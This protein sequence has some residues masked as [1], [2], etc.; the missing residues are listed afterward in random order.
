MAYLLASRDNL[1]GSPEKP[2]SD[3]G[4]MAFSRYWRY[5]VLEYL[6]EHEQNSV[7]IWDIVKH[8]NFAGV[9]I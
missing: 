7:T 5:R 4:Y 3:L 9:D 8:T 2:L 6:T 1:I